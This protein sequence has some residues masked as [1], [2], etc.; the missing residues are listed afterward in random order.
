MYLCMYVFMCVCNVL[1]VRLCIIV[2]VVLCV[3][4][5]ISVSNEC[6]DE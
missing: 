2:C 3:I 4:D 1:H 5:G 6:M